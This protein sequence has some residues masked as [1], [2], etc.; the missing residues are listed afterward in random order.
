LSNPPY[1][2][3]GDIEH[4]DASVKDY[5][6]RVALDGGEDGME[7]H[8]RVLGGCRDRLRAGG[9]VYVEIQFD[10]GES[11]SEIARGTGHLEDVRVLKDAA[12]HE[13]VVT[14]RGR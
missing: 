7:L 2:P 6:P 1:I 13:R 10:Q 9:R 5:E 11:V 3:T 14:G 12:G 8:R 4:L